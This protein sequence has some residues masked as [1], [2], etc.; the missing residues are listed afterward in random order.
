MHT[1]PF[2]NPRRAYSRNKDRILAVFDRVMSAGN[3]ILRKELS[4]FED[5]FAKFINVKYAVGVSS[6]YASIYMALRA[7]GVSTGDAVIVP[8]HTHVSTCSAVINAGATPVLIDIDEDFNMNIN[9]LEELINDRKDIKAIIPVH[10]N[11]LMCDMREIMRV[12]KNYELVVIEDACQAVGASIENRFAGTWSNAGCFSFYPFKIL[13]CYGDG[14]CLI[15]NDKDIESIVRLLRFNGEDRETGEYK[16]HGCSCTLDN[17]QAAFLSMKLFGLDKTLSRR[18]EIA[19]TYNIQLSGI[20]DMI[21]PICTDVDFL[22]S[23]Q[24]YVIR[25]QYRDQIQKYLLK[26]GIEI[27]V[28]WRLPYYKHTRLNLL[29]KTYPVMERISKEILSLPIYSELEDDEVAIII[30]SIKNFFG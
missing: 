2:A 9:L 21:L 23:Y 20:G 1:I 17:L 4:Q 13:G 6:G 10:M 19:E 30:N 18:R 29:S 12:A 5:D 3:L 28:H 27:K 22:H 8:V 14:G 24:N 25:S 15:T 16:F 26:K 7:S 11:G